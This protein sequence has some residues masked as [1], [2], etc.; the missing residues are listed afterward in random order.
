MSVRVA[1]VGR[2]DPSDPDHRAIDDFLARLGP[3]FQAPWIAPDDAA[4][5]TSAD[6]IWLAPRPPWTGGPVLPDDRAAYDIGA[7]A[8]RIGVPLLAPRPGERP[9]VGEAPHAYVSAFLEHARA[10]ALAREAWQAEQSRALEVARAEALPRPYV[11]QLRG[12][13]MRWWRPVAAFALFLVTY[14]G[15]SLAVMIP[16]VL[17]GTLTTST[18]AYEVSATNNLFLNLSLAALIP[19][20]L[21]TSRVV[22]GRSPGRVFSVTG[23]LRWGWLL[24]AM[25]VVTPLWLV[26]LTLSWFLSGQ[27]LLAR[28]KD[29]LT[30]TVVTLLTT[31]LQS[32][33]EEVAFRGGFTQWIGSWMR[34]PVMA[35]GV[36]SVV[37]T[38]LFVAAHG[39]F[40]PWTMID[41]G[42]LGVAACVLAWR[43]GGIEAGIAL[44]VVNNLLITFAGIG[45]GGLEQSYVDGSTTGDPLSALISIIV[46]TMATVLL[47]R[48]AKRA[49]LAPA[50]RTAPAIG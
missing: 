44:H 36:A 31:P 40:D 20:V 14:L 34:S 23:R 38:G 18:A 24:R 42:S 47:L 39:T 26:Y 16:F 30:L 29:W 22:Y 2:R 37:T 3:P 49:G 5:I 50:G 33:G 17:A 43:T 41:I 45:L 19:A 9:V 46:M 10:R 12:P 6:G 27:E 13:R 15:V 11:H 1:V 4:S 21:V 7:W 28:P 32:A 8:N 25:A 35:F 48:Q